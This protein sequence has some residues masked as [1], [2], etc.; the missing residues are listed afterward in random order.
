MGGASYVPVTTSIWQPD[1]AQVAGLRQIGE[2]RDAVA[3]DVRV[4]A[5][6]STKLADFLDRG[7]V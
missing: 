2:A 7:L 4:R 3:G 5:Q 6:Q 1:P